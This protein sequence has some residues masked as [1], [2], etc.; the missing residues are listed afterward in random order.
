MSLMMQ[1]HSVCASCAARL[2]SFK[3]LKAGQILFKVFAP[4]LLSIFS[5]LVSGATSEK[6]IANIARPLN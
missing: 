5:V 6:R 4:L 3:Q 1:W 2:K